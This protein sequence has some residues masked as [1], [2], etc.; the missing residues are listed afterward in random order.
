V[1]PSFDVP[2][3]PPPK[4]RSPWTWIIVVVAVIVLLG[5]LVLCSVFVIVPALMPTPTPT[6]TPTATFTA[7]PAATSTPT[8]TP[9]P[10]ISAGELIYEQDFTDPGDEWEQSESDDVIY[11]IDN[12]AYSIEV[13]KESWLAWNKTG[14]DVDDFILECDAALV[15]GNKYNAYGILF[16][17]QDKDNRYELTINGN[18]SFT[19]GKKVD[20]EWSELLDWTPNDAIKGV[21]LVNHIRLIGYQGTF[22]LYVNDQFVYEF[23]DDDLT[24]GQIAPSVT[25]YDNPPARA[26]FDNWTVWKAVK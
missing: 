26:T 10:S 19:V 4:K 13:L 16:A 14:H 5:C 11:E 21:G 12:G 1:E 15:E 3:A 17:Y 7:T 2:A 20:G 8:A 23:S 22:T 18:G 25:A 6:A 9:T 24:E